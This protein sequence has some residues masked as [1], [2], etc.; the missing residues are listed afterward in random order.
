MKLKPYNE[1]RLCIIGLFLRKK[2]MEAQYNDLSSLEKRP[3]IDF[4]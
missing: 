3:Y 2:I 4:L 1:E